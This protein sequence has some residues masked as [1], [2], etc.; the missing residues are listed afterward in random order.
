[1]RGK[2]EWVESGKKEE[3]CLV[4]NEKKETRFF[5][6]YKLEKVIK[7]LDH[8]WCFILIYQKEKVKNRRS[9]WFGD[10]LSV[11]EIIT[12]I[13]GGSRIIYSI[14]CFYSHIGVESR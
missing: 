8:K 2:N 13:Y 11:L 6:F 14:K 5:L 4:N 10:K 9:E 7:A 1:M 3:N 12:L